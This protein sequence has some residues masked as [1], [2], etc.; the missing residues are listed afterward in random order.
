MMFENMTAGTLYR[1]PRRADFRRGD[2]AGLAARP[3]RKRRAREKTDDSERRWI[4]RC[5]SH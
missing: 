3:P 1:P 5:R 4:N 2:A